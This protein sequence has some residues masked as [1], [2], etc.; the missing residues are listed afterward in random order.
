MATGRLPRPSSGGHGAGYAG[1]LAGSDGLLAGKEKE[2]MQNLNGRLA[3]YLHKVCALETASGDLEVKMRDW[4]REQRPGPARDYSHYLRTIE[5]L[6]DKIPGATVENSKVVLQIDNARLAAG[7]FPTKFEM[8]QALARADLQMQIGGLKEELACL[9][10]NHEE[11]VSVL[12]GQVTAEKNR[13]DAEAWFTSQTEELNKEVA[14]HTEQLQ[15]SKTDATKLRRTLQGLKM[16]L[17]P[18]LSVEA[19]VDGPLAETEARIA[20]QPAQIQALISGL[21]AQLSDV[22]ADMSGRTSRTRSTSSSWTSTIKLQSKSE[23]LA[24]ALL[25]NDDLGLALKSSD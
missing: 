1:P 14:G 6:R 24:C 21:E 17:Q 3:S 4:Y 9:K 19:A 23:N 12:R 5:D 18:Q 10:K 11:E 16:E 13:K 7:D 2:T 15:I 8:E 25:E 20:A 22:R